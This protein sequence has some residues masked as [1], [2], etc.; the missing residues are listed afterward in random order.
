MVYAPH[1]AVGKE[2][3][4]ARL[5]S[6]SILFA[7]HAAAPVSFRPLAACHT[8]CQLPEPLLE[9][10]A[11]L[12]VLRHVAQHLGQTGQHPSV[13]TR[14]ETLSATGC[15]HFGINILRVAVIQLGLR[16][17]H[18]AVAPQVIL[19]H[20]IQEHAV[21]RQLVHL[22]H[23]RHHHVECI[24]PPP[25]LVLIQMAGVRHNLLRTGYLIIGRVQGIHVNVGLETNLPV[26]EEH[27]ILAL[28]VSLVLPVPLVIAVCAPPTVMFA[29]LLAVIVICRLACQAVGFHVSGVISGIV[30]ERT[31]LGRIV[32]L[33]IIVYFLYQLQ[34]FSRPR[35]ALC[36]H[37]EKHSHAPQ[38]H[39]H[40]QKLEIKVFHVE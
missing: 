21:A 35:A 23:Q 5:R 24:C 28:P 16:I 6:R 34:D 17:I 8:L 25:E 10:S 1:Q 13:A 15:L 32:R 2:C 14:P 11:V 4:T 37:R 38:D 7:Q 22:R 20:A 18:Q 29:P 36:R 26:A 3:R 19:I 39:P 27:E 9:E 30:P 31:H 40:A 33:P 12:I